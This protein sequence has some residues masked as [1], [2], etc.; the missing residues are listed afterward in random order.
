MKVGKVSQN[1][2]KR[3]VLNLL[4]YKGPHKC[5]APTM[6]DPTVE[7]F[8]DDDSVVISTMTNISGKSTDIGIYA[9]TRGV[10][11][12][13][14]RWAEPTG[15]Q[16]LI[17]LPEQ[18]NE[19]HLK[20]MVQ[21]MESHCEKIKVPLLY[22]QVSV[23]STVS[24]PQVTITALGIVG[25]ECLKRMNQGKVDMD[26]VMVGEVG[27]EGALHLLSEKREN[28]E[29]R[30]TPLFLRGLE[31]KSG[32]I[33]ESVECT[34][35]IRDLEYEIIHQVPEAG[36]LGGLWELAEAS[37]LGIEVQLKALAISQETIE[38]CEYLGVNPYR[39]G[40]AGTVLVLAEDGQDFVERMKEY[41]YKAVIIGRT[42]EGKEKLLCN[43]DDIRHIERPTSN[44]L[45]KVLL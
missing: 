38:V 14:C 45:Y 10:N 33:V 32:K 37:E 42:T 27:L 40:A 35:Q 19:S 34:S 3:S 44:E 29:E 21:A 13:L 25:I 12:V 31:E 43:Q 22:V 1:V 41:S 36:I 8:I 28:L 2:L 23:V 9:I 7:T 6:E 18:V 20:S 17:L 15:V 11:D 24:S 5:S 16:A 30:F 26:I 4:Q 39:L